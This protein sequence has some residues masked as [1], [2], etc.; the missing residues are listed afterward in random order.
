MFLVFVFESVF[1]SCGNSRTPMYVLGAGSIVNLALDPLLIL[2]V[3]PFPRLE[4][5]G[6]VL[7][8]AISETLVLAVYCVLA[9][10]GAFP[11]RIRW[12][13]LGRAISLPRSGA[14]L[15]IGAP[16][17]VTGIL[18]SA[19]YLFLSKV[20][21]RF[22]SGSLAALG[23]VNRLESLN[24]LTSVAMGMAVAAMVGQNLGGQRPDRAERAAHRGAALITILT[25]IMT[26]VYLA[27]PEPIV[28]IFV[29]DFEAV[30]EGVEFLRIVAISQIFMG[31]EIVY[32][33]AFMGA[34]N[35][36]P[37]MHVAV[38]TSTVR[39]PMAWATAFP[40]GMGSTG[41]W[42]TISLTCIA[43]GLWITAWFRRFVPRFSAAGARARGEIPSTAEIQPAHM[44]VSPESSPDPH[45]G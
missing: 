42:W 40:L 23:V 41:V 20:T 37:P 7:A 4:V 32:G 14:I 21:G 24:Y 18:Y 28:R 27:F 12:R 44:P 30:R 13:A 38:A 9:A 33:G 25:T 3:G 15:R 6:A 10:K 19:V 11:L 16:Q 29:S 1:R 8:L 26:L 2:G 22:G 17:A 45:A 39:F 43:R 31:W 34:G 36:L 5:H 35:T